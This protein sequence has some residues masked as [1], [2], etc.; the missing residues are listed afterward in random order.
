[1][2]ER[3]CIRSKATRHGPFRFDLLSTTIS[4]SIPCK[5]LRSNTLTF[6]ISHPAL[7]MTTRRRLSLFLLVLL[8]LLSTCT[9]SANAQD[10]D[11]GANNNGGGGDNGKGGGNNN[12]GGNGGGGGKGSP[13]SWVAPQGGFDGT[14]NGTCR[15]E[16]N[17]DTTGT[18]S[19][20]KAR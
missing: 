5:S 7:D 15:L 11:N 19:N 3:V 8:T 9:F 20:L 14:V 2:E 17:K 4:S 13:P 16:W 1:M 10:E 6:R 18:L 12:G